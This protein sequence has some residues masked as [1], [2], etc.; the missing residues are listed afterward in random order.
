MVR[1]SKTATSKFPSD[2][3]RSRLNVALTLPGYVQDVNNKQKTNFNLNY[4]N[5]FARRNHDKK[6][7]TF[8]IW[9]FHLI[10][11]LLNPACTQYSGNIRWV[12][13]QCCNVPRIQGTSRE[14]FKGKY[15][16]K[17]YRMGKSF[18]R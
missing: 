5:Q 2:K 17:N 18:L 12:F 14:H 13:P 9:Y 3:S 4:C 7:N 10:N 8:K 16:L 11:M 15:F 6:T 1:R